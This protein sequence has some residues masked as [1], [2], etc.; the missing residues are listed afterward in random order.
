MRTDQYIRD[1]TDKD[2]Y[3]QLGINIQ[4][5]ASQLLHFTSGIL[6]PFKLTFQ[7]YNVLFILRGASPNGMSIKSICDR[8]IDRNSNCSRLVDKLVNKGWAIR[9]ESRTDK[10]IVHVVI[11]DGGMLLMNEAIIHLEIKFI[12]RM[13]AIEHQ[14]AKMLNLI[15]E[16][17]K[18]Q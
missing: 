10:R 7:Q 11:T 12:E 3:I 17:L 15:L 2:E 8:M 5:T 16:K 13:Q 14:E 4:T 9:K 1:D 6:K 18:K